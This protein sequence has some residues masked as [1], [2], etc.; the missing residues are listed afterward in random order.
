MREIAKKLK[1]WYNA[2]YYLLHRTAQTGSNQ[3]I[4]SFTLIK[5][6]LTGDINKGSYV[7]PGQSVMER[8]GVLNVL[9]TQCII[10]LH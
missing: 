4:W 6:Y 5:M 2:V 1:I 7:S 10:E 9:Y 8:A 3:S